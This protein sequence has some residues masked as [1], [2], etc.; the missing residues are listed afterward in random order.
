MKRR[1][2]MIA[3]LWLAGSIPLALVLLVV[4][5]PVIFVP[6]LW[7]GYTCWDDDTNN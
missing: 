7:D 6:G 3:A 5:W 2:K 1:D 4:G